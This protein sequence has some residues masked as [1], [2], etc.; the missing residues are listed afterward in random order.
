MT[1]FGLVTVISI[2]FLAGLSIFAIYA[3][4]DPISLGHVERK[5]QMLPY[6]VMDNLG[7][8]MGIPGL[9]VACLFSGTM[10]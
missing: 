1:F 2:L 10:R 7:F 8:M 9:F 5:D 4:C 3:G 6:Y